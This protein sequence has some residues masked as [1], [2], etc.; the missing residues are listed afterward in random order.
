MNDDIL[1]ALGA[2]LDQFEV[3]DEQNNPSLR[4]LE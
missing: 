3:E 1:K 4:E 2:L